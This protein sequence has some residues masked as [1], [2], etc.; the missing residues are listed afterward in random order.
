[1]TRNDLHKVLCRIHERVKN[2]H[3]MGV[4]FCPREGLHIVRVLY[5]QREYCFTV[6]CW[7]LNVLCT[8]HDELASLVTQKRIDLM[9]IIDSYH[10]TVEQSPSTSH[11]DHTTPAMPSENTQ[12]T[13]D[14]LPH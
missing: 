3:Y 10:D 6:S 5:H 14:D 1:M 13:V 8:T 4:L 11:H 9:A 7:E 12:R 2:P